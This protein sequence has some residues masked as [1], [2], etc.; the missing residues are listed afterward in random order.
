MP[1]G[2]A[3]IRRSVTRGPFAL[4][5]EV[6]GAVQD[7]QTGLTSLGAAV[8]AAKTLASTLPGTVDKV[9]ITIKST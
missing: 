8:D 4:V 6:D 1:I 2:I 5:Y 9:Q 7:V 3:V